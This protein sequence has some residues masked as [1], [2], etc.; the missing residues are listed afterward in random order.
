[1]L[2]TDPKCLSNIPKEERPRLKVAEYVSK[3]NLV[4]QHELISTSNGCME[5]NT[6]VTS[7]VAL[8]CLDRVLSALGLTLNNK[9]EAYSDPTLK[10]IFMLNNYNYMLKTL[11]RLS[12]VADTGYLLTPISSI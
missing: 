1:M 12:L 8:F 4:L 6:S 10:A 2:C 9:S 3:Y 7:C 11:R 5:F